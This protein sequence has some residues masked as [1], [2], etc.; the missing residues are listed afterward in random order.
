MSTLR[1]MTL[2]VAAASSIAAAL[3]ACSLLP[4]PSLSDWPKQVKTNFMNACKQTSNGQ[5]GYCKCALDTL[6][7]TYDI[8]DYTAL[9]NKLE[10]SEEAVNE[11]MAVIQP[12]LDAIG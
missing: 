12:C 1:R 7:K 4:T 3:S 5:G 11:F 9:E 8:E 10:D 2:T 6:E